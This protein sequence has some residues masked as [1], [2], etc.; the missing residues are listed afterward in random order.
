ML[1]LHAGARFDT[2]RQFVEPGATHAA[3]GWPHEAV[4][5]VAD[6]QSSPIRVPG[7][8]GNAA[9][10]MVVACVQLLFE[11]DAL[12]GAWFKNFF[13]LLTRTCGLEM[14]CPADLTRLN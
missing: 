14:S 10:V 9:H 3:A 1:E 12:I 2:L 11:L 13:Y 5:P 7:L 4:E 6:G 8:N